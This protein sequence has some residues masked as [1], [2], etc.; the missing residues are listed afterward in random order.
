MKALFLGLGGVGQRH[1]RNLLALRPDATAF[2]VRH[3]GRRFEIGND[4][5][6]ADGVDVIA[7]Y[8]V[9]VLPTLEAALAEKPDV[10]IIASPSARH[11][12]QATAT[13][14][15]GVPTFVEKPLAVERAGL[16]SLYRL[17]LARKT[18]VMVGYQLRYH[19]SVKRLKEHVDA[20]TVGRVRSIE[21]AVHSHMPSWHGYEK[22]TDFYAGVRALGGGVT[23]TE[24]HEIDLL[25][26]LFGPARRVSAFA[27]A[28]SGLGLDVEETVGAAV[29]MESGAVATVCL[30][31]VQRP[32]TRRFIVNGDR[33][34]IGMDIPASRLTVIDDEG[35]TADLLESGDFDR[36]ELFK[37][38]LGDFLEAAAGGVARHPL[39][40]A[41][42]GQ[43][44]ALAIRD[45]LETGRVVALA[46]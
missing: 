39:E 24:I 6:A 40:S 34:R 14:G 29:E 33:G 18:P 2:A 30:S 21:I 16:D 27:A 9:R 19:P 17:A 46:A 43:D 1:L 32:P 15:A 44:A 4:L 12:D 11:V 8:G 28:P 31:F 3:G 38:E 45:A 26:W 23:L 25:C 7:K 5:K 37:A 13:V 35:R 41:R 42:A 36:N 10:A 20:G 22:P